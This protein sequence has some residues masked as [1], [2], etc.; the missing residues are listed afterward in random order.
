MKTTKQQ[1]NKKLKTKKIYD[2]ENNECNPNDSCSVRELR[3]SS[4]SNEVGEER[5][6]QHGEVP[7]VHQ[8]GLPTVHSGNVT[9]TKLH[10]NRQNYKQSINQQQKH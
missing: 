10:D 1:N 6:C 4:E 7:H 3:N 2:H 8:S 9:R 5:S